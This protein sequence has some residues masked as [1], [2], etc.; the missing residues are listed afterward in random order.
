MKTDLVF[1]ELFTKHVLSPG[2]PE[3][4][5]RV[6]TALDALKKS[7]LLD[8]GRVNMLQPRPAHSDE[9]RTI[10]SKSY[11]EEVKER[12]DSGGG[13]F[14][15]DTS[16]NEY[17]FDAAMHAAGGGIQTVNRILDGEAK[18]SFILCRPP[19]H[20]AEYDR[21]LGFCFINNIAV[22]ARHLVSRR[23]MRRVLII[24]YDAHHGNGTQNA[25]YSEREVFYV[26]IHQDGR[27]LFPGTGFVHERG[28]GK[29][30]GY[31][32]NL[33][34]YPG[35]GD[36]SYDLLLR[37]IIK[38]LVDEFSPEFILISAGFDCHFRDRLTSL[39]L[40]TSGIAKMNNS[41]NQ[42]AK[43]HCEGR[44]AFFLEGGYDL[45]VMRQA[46]VNLIE[47][48]TGLPRTEYG[49]VMEENTV[50]VEKTRQL[51]ETVEKYR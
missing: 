24:D 45:D 34:M 20:H 4:P 37:K 5:K 28:E 12:S 46:S 51:I 30:E 11:L 31:N 43:D 41:L 8:S 44:I 27:T 36:I 19:G 39:S 13:Y 17:T 3:S 26:G 22:A 1:H 6:N 48:L 29:G 10:H 40:T 32:V 14:T 49:D 7:D 42:I 47:V 38:P 9:V 18:N 2:H 16:V 23:G 50:S 21:A 15:L 35:C 25:F 33:P